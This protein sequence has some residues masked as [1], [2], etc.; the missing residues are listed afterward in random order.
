MKTD[1]DI[2]WIP[3]SKAKPVY[4]KPL[5]CAKKRY[6]Y[7]TVLNSAVIPA[8]VGTMLIVFG[9]RFGR[10]IPLIF[11]RWPLNS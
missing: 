3:L 4:R 9:G 6:E 7:R 11:R 10:N 1:E 5:A 8:F 2:V